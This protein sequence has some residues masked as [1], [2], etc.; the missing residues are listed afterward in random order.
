VE[1]TGD[2]R[3]ARDL[4]GAKDVCGAEGVR[5]RAK[6]R[7]GGYGGQ[8]GWGAGAPHARRLS[9]GELHRRGSWAESPAN[10][11]G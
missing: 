7:C 6:A 3:C 8:G 9:P 4:R 2:V 1:G 10:T 11:E 5:V